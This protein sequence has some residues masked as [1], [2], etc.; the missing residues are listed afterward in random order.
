MAT[1]LRNMAV[2]PSLWHNHDMAAM[3]FQPGYRDKASLYPKTLDLCDFFKYYCIFFSQRK[4][5]KGA[6]FQSHFSVDCFLS[7]ILPSFLARFPRNR[8]HFFHLS[9]QLLICYDVN[10]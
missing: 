5:H 9:G 2:M 8:L 6:V 3:F 7:F 10:E 4:C 1:M